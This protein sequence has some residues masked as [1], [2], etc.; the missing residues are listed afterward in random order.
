MLSGE[1]FDKLN[2]IGQRARDNS[3]ELFGGL[4]LVLCG[5]FYQLPPISKFLY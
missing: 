4:Q 1:I 3:N 2:I 5:D